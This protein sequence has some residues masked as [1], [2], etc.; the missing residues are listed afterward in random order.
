L[1]NR[2]NCIAIPCYGLDEYGEV[3]PQVVHDEE[4]GGDGDRSAKLP[5]SLDKK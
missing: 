2:E 5:E 3:A 1:T 4:E